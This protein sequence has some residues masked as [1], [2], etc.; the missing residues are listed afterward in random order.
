MNILF[1]TNGPIFPSFHTNDSL[2]G[3]FH[4]NDPVSHPKIAQPSVTHPLD[5]ARPPGRSV[6]TKVGGYTKK[7]SG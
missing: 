7:I 3:L 1:H 4:T 5:L 6:K 2:L